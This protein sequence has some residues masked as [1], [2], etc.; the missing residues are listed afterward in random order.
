MMR[1]ILLSA[2]TCAIVLL[3]PLASSQ[4]IAQN[5]CATPQDMQNL[6]QDQ[7]GEHVVAWGQLGTPS[8]RLNHLMLVYV[9]PEIDPSKPDSGRSWSIV[10]R[11]D[12]RTSSYFAGKSCIIASGWGYIHDPGLVGAPT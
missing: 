6:L 2:T 12:K 9:N 10:I 3:G 7:Y 1:N 11:Y 5:A 8:S 4:P